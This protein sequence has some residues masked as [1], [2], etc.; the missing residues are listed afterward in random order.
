MF[1]I[2]FTLDAQPHNIN[3][4]RVPLFAVADPQLTHAQRMEAQ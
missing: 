3:L 4:F 2:F 1:A